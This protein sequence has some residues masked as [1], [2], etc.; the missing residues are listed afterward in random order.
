MRLYL[1][2]RPEK[3]PADRYGKQVVL[4]EMCHVATRQAGA[5][6]ARFFYELLRCVCSGSRFA[7]ADWVDHGGSQSDHPQNKDAS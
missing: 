1:D 5:H 3:I 6:G 2:L 7:A 4:H